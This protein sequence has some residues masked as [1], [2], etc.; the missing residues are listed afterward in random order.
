V[1]EFSCSFQKTIRFIPSLS[2]GI[3]LSFLSIVLLFSDISPLAS[4]LTESPPTIQHQETVFSKA[5][6]ETL[7]IPET[8]SIEPDSSLVDVDQ[9]P[10][11]SDSW[12]TDDASLIPLKDA[13]EHIRQNYSQDRILHVFHD[14]LCPYCKRNFFEV[15]I[16]L[17]RSEFFAENG[18]SIRFSAAPLSEES[19][20]LLKA[21]KC[22]HAQQKEWEFLRE[23]FLS[24]EQ[25]LEKAR[26]IVTAL[27]LN[28]DDFESCLVSEEVNQEIEQDKAFL[29]ESGI[30]AIPAIL[31]FDTR[32]QGIYPPENIEKQIRNDLKI[33]P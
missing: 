2:I 17:S 9:K 28:P 3:G 26:E 20:P 32:Y 11:S 4:S 15:M 18:I 21:Q 29:E 7:V 19:L 24:T 6:E 1:K 16:P 23:M 5:E 14:F 30:T 10:L 33:I 13:G 25:N 8:F 12:N 22:V 31:F 27:E